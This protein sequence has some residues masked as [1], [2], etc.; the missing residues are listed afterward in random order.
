MSTYKRYLVLLE[1]DATLNIKDYDKI[2][3]VSSAE[4]AS[5]STPILA[6]QSYV[7]SRAVTSPYTSSFEKVTTYYLTDSEATTLASDPS[8]KYVTRDYDEDDPIY[9]DHNIDFGP[10]SGSYRTDESFI[11]ANY[12]Y[13]RGSWD[14]SLD[15]GL[16][17][18]YATFLHSL[19]SESAYSSSA[20]NFFGNKTAEL[21]L[22]SSS[23]S[24]PDIIYQ[25][26]DTNN[27]NFTNYAVDGK[28]VDIVICEGSSNPFLPNN[29]SKR[30]VNSAFDLH[31]PDFYGQDG[32]FRIQLINWADYG[33]N[34]ATNGF[35]MAH[36]NWGEST[37]P[38]HR[39]MVGSTAAGLYNGFAKG[40][41]IYF[42]PGGGSEGSVNI[43]KNFHQNK[44]VN[45]L[46]GRRNPTIVNLSVG[47]LYQYPYIGHQL[48]NKASG[49]FD[50]SDIENEGRV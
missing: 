39:Q 23:V 29:P 48:G 18:N 14:A 32:T 21:V 20:K 5:L 4:Y 47:L 7:P 46:T 49:S 3:K 37:S 38:P 31:H 22:G 9:S 19:P 2:V 15:K 44:P 12:R 16:W 10:D 13:Q 41:N 43:I 11:K 50:L 8:I 26:A 1:K 33:W 42:F 35:Y 17:G 28:N 34:Y 40:A 30:K 25:N 45:P 6:K 36:P 24:S 27:I